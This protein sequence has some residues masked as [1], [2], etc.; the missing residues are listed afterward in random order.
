MLRPDS[1]LWFWTLTVGQI[2]VLTYDPG[3]VIVR[4]HPLTQCHQQPESFFLC[5]VEQQDRG[6][7]VHG[8]KERRGFINILKTGFIQTD[9]WREQDEADLD[10]CLILM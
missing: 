9:R 5:A 2:L 7:D 1:A 4:Q 6:D 8:L 3:V 10:Q